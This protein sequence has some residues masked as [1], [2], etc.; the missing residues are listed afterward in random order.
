M[1][2]LDA[3]QANGRRADDVAFQMMAEPTP[4]PAMADVDVE[5]LVPDGL[6]TRIDLELV[7][8]PREGFRAILF[9]D[10]ARL[11]GRWEQ[12]FLRSYVALARSVASTASVAQ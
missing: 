12:D 11:D 5:V 2:T 4:R 7:L 10:R 8:V 3:I 9:Y 1:L 6:G